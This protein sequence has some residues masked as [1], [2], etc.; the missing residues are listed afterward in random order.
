MAGYWRDGAES[1]VSDILRVLLSLPSSSP[2]ILTLAPGV[3]HATLTHHPGALVRRLSPAAGDGG[4]WANWFWFDSFRL[5]RL[6]WLRAMAPL[7]LGLSVGVVAGLALV[8]LL[9]AARGAGPRQLF[10][11]QLQPLP[12]RALRLLVWA[13]SVGIGLILGLTAAPR[14]E[15]L[16]LAANAPPFGMAD[17]IFG[18]DAS[19]YV[20]ILPV[21]NAGR[22]WVIEL[23]ILVTIAVTGQYI[24][25][26]GAS[27]RRGRSAS[28]VAAGPS[29]APRQPAVASS[30]RLLDRAFGALRPSGAVA[31]RMPM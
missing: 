16:L 7:A 18:L 15:T 24:L 14:W 17:P 26:T 23:V 6:V 1:Q 9:V 4:T 31:R 2:L 21:L 22:G 12:Q 19:F 30:P 27:L 3:Y 5:G 28:T 11:G 8:N 20:F 13:A 25:Q 29:G 10:R